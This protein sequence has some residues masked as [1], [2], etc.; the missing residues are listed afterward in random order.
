MVNA[1]IQN[2]DVMGIVKKGEKADL[3]FDLIPQGKDIEIGNF[4]VSS[5]LSGLFPPGLLI[6][7][8]KRMISSDAQIYQTAEIDPAIDFNILNKVFVISEK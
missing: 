4:V 5:G 3:T 1:R 7:K 8:I 2:S 6:G